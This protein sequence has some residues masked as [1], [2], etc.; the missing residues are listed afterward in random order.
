MGIKASAPV[1][2]E[3]S[4]FTECPHCE[5]CEQIGVGGDSGFAGNEHVCA[6]CGKSFILEN[7]PEDP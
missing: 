7:E 1:F 5:H 2:A 3:I 6:G 4:Y